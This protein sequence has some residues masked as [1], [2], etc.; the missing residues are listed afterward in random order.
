[1]ELN[2]IE[3][4]HFMFRPGY[5][6]GIQTRFRFRWPFFSIF[7]DSGDGIPPELRN[8]NFEFRFRFIPIFSAGISNRKFRIGILAEK[9]GIGI[10]FFKMIS[11][12]FGCT[13]N[14]LFLNPHFATA[15]FVKDPLRLK[16]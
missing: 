8:S 12:S 11:K 6:I 1:M 15:H 4:K 7:L 3:E 13:T 16:D 5:E 10:P 9:I 14:S 2:R